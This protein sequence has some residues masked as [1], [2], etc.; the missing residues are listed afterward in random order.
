MNKAYAI[1]PSRAQERILS[2]L[3]V[4]MKK[5]AKKQETD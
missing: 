4:S 1:E 5:A 3:I 2:N